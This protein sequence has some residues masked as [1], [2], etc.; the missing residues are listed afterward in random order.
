[1]SK[2]PNLIVKCILKLSKIFEKIID[3][4]EVEQILLSMHEYLLSV[5]HEN[6]SQNDETA[7]KVLKTVINELVKL[8]RDQIWEAY[9]VIKCHN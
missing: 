9:S 6:K 3:K 4:L 8:K 7:I 1:M 2:I 5:N